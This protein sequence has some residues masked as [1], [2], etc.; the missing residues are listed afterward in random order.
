MRLIDADV[1]VKELENINGYECPIY[2]SEVIEMVKYQ[3]RLQ[4]KHPKSCPCSWCDDRCLG[5]YNCSE[6]EDW[7]AGK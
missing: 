3:D 5:A 4:P 2:V 6:F 7:L 1:L